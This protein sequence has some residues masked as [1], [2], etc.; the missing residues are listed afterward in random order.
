MNS[1]NHV[2]FGSVGEWIWRNVVGLNPDEENP[3]WK[4]FIVKPQP[5]GDL[6]FARGEYK[7]IRGTIVSD[8]KIEGKT[9]KL[10][11]TVPPNCTATVIMPGEEEGKTIESGTYQFESS[12]K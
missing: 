9:F 11:V 1:F 12:V 6:T 5:G 7:S 2:A 4:H 8:W 3:G 10:S